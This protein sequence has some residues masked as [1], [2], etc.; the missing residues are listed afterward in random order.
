MAYIIDRNKN[1]ICEVETDLKNGNEIIYAY[2]YCEESIN[3]NR[4]KNLVNSR[5]G[6]I[7]RNKKYASE[8]REVS[9]FR[10]AK[11]INDGEFYIVEE[12]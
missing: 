3:A 9:C 2:D 6:K 1:L 7:S 11:E 12:D 8:A 10:Y 5:T 4:D